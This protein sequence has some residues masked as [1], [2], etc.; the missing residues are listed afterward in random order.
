MWNKDVI[1]TSGS[2]IRQ[3]LRFFFFF[4]ENIAIEKNHVD[5]YGRVIR[6]DSSLNGYSDFRIINALELNRKIV[7][8]Q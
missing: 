6:L 7:I 5:F 3:V 4:N 2:R 1:G 8:Y